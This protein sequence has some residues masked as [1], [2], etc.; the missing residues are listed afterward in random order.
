MHTHH[1][2][3]DAAGLLH[4]SRMLV[5]FWTYTAHYY[6]YFLFKGKKILCIIVLAKGKREINV[7]IDRAD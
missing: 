6:E 5:L 2:Q 3:R 4:P 1:G 7:L